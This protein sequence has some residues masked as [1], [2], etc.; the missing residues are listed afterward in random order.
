MVSTDASNVTG[1][2]KHWQTGV[3]VK[4]VPLEPPDSSSF[5]SGNQRGFRRADFT[6]TLGGETVRFRVAE[7]FTFRRR[8]AVV[9]RTY[10]GGLSRQFT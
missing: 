3:K 1:I 8:R 9:T 5:S 7:T 2:H 10:T 4:F 6:W